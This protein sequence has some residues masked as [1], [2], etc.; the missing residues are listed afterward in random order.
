MDASDRLALAVGSATL[1]TTVGAPGGA[2]PCPATPTGYL[3]GVL[4]GTAWKMPYYAA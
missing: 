2:S 4:N 1:T 3:D